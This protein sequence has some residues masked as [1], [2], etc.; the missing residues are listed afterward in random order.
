[1]R[2]SDIPKATV[3]R[4]WAGRPR[5]SYELRHSMESGGS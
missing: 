2:A 3:S 5:H 1:M 4:A